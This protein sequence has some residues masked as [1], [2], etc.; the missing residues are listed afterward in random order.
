AGPGPWSLFA[1][2]R[3]DPLTER[4]GYVQTPNDDPA[5]LYQDVLI[6][7]DRRRGI[8]IGEPSLHARCLDALSPKA[9]ETVVQVGA[10]SGYYTALLAHLVGPNGQV[11]AFEIDP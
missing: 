11:V 2:D 6:A 3:W 1:P 8:N 4:S 10:G 9:G 7:L 5:F